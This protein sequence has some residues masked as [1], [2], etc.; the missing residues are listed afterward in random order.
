MP[1][2]WLRAE[3]S[4]SRHPRMK[5]MARQ[6]KRKCSASVPSEIV[7]SQFALLRT[8][9]SDGRCCACRMRTPK[10]SDFSFMLLSH[11]AGDFSDIQP[12]PNTTKRNNKQSVAVRT[13]QCI[14]AQCI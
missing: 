3:S 10:K 4:R 6:E 14:D 12:K 11:S 8:R 13:A 5:L 9:Y 2:A 7:L 1:A